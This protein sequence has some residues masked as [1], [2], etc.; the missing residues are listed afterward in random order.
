MFKQLKRLG[1]EDDRHQ[2]FHKNVGGVEGHGSAVGAW[3][4]FPGP[5]MQRG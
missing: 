5:V 3:E 4:V 2:G 1:A